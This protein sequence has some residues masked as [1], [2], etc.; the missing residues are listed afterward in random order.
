MKNR[1]GVQVGLSCGDE[2]SKLTLVLRLD[3][4]D[5][6]DSG[7]LLVDDRAEAG[8]AFDN[9]VRDT[10]LPAECG[11]EDDEFNRVDVVGDDDQGGLLC[12][13]KGNTVVQTV[14]G[15]EGL[16]VL[17]TSTYRQS[18]TYIHKEWV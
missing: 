9:D 10:H 14:L 16:L 5:S 2:S 17:Q 4:L 1:N 18:I 12:F 15:E 6:K 8:L 3:L 13:N 11:E 7:S